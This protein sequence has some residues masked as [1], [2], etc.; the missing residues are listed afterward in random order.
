MSV[1]LVL[2]F[3]CAIWVNTVGL[4]WGLPSSHAKNI[5]LPASEQ[6]EMRYRAMS[7]EHQK[8]FDGSDSVFVSKSLRSATLPD[9]VSSKQHRIDSSVE[10]QGLVHSIERSFLI[11]TFEPDLTNIMNAFSR[12]D[13]RRLDFFPDTFC[14]GILYFLITGFFLK[15]AEV[16]RFIVVQSDLVFYLS[17]S[18]YLA[19][20]YLSL[21]VINLLYSFLTGLILFKLVNQFF[22]KKLALY[23]TLLFLII[24]TTV[25]SNYV[26][27]PHTLGALFCLLVIYFV[28]CIVS[29]SDRA[30]L[31]FGAS[32]SAGLAYGVM[33]TN[34]LYGV[35]LGVAFVA[36][37]K[38][39]NWYIFSGQ[40]LGLCVQLLAPYLIIVLFF[41]S[42]VF[43]YPNIFASEIR[44][45]SDFID[46]RNVLGLM[47]E[48]FYFVP[49]ISSYLGLPLVILSI[50]GMIMWKKMRPLSITLMAI[51][52]LFYLVQ[53]TTVRIRFL[54]PI[55]PYMIV[56]AL[57]CFYHL[58]DKK[59][60]K[61]TVI[62]FL[63]VT[64]VPL[65][66]S[67]AEALHFKADVGPQ[68]TRLQAGEWINS[69]IEPGSTIGFNKVPVSFM[70]PPFQF[71]KYELLITPNVMDLGDSMTEKPDFL[72]YTRISNSD[73]PV[74]ENIELIPV[75]RFYNGV[76]IN[77]VAFF[78]KRFYTIA[79]PEIIIYKVIYTEPHPTIDKNYPSDENEFL[80]IDESQYPF[81][82][83][84]SSH[85][86]ASSSL[87][88][89]QS[90]LIKT[91]L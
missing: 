5:V 35:L 79:N 53:Q 4:S 87:D 77:K 72:V 69:T 18:V 29:G 12:L 82:E 90:V 39:K 58:L 36:V 32:L 89:T 14:Y 75:A 68:S 83:L 56:M 73:L 23:A 19:R 61:T 7:T 88:E 51:F 21:R 66:R 81:D 26:V 33:M 49:Y 16:F 62:L 34:G 2:F 59:F 70:S 17:H 40:S 3:L 63:L 46:V 50:I 45:Q 91:E 64:L 20:I 67:Y 85:Q 41:S 76:S 28:M 52:I 38:R 54:L 1:F 30:E 65:G 55:V 13:L 57:F 48:I 11:R 31:Y 44:L 80:H 43:L 74:I 84:D 10:S 78:R 37:L 25:I 60:Y 42:Y 15:I 24:P 47:K 27:K 9:Y 6:N 22:S 71:S 8:L 86:G